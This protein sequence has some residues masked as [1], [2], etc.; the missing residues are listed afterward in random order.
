MQA[1]TPPSTH[2]RNASLPS[3]SIVNPSEKASG[4]VLK[5]SLASDAIGRIGAALKNFF[6]NFKLRYK[7]T[8]LYN[9]ESGRPLRKK[10][11]DRL[12]RA[13]EGVLNANSADAAQQI[14]LDAVTIGKLLQRIAMYK[15]TDYLHSLTLDTLAYRDK[16]YEW[17]RQDYRNLTSV[18]GHPL[19]PQ[20]QARYQVCEDTAAQ[21]IQ[22]IDSDI[23]NGIKET[24][25]DGIQDCKSKAQVSQDLFDKFG[26][27]NRSWKRIADT[28]TVNISNLASILEEVHTAGAGEKVYFQ[29]H[30][31]AGCCKKCEQANGKIA[32]WSA[33]PLAS[34]EIEDPF[35]SVAIW[36]SK[37][38][39]S[40]RG[41]L[42]PGAL[43]PHCRGF[44]V[45]WGAAE[46][47]AQAAEVN[48]KKKEWNEAV[49]NV[50]A[51]YKAQGIENPDDSTK[52]YTKRINEV[53]RGA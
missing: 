26:E 8:V 21:L 36:D 34:D 41:T 43:H 14:T 32:L 52:G 3:S 48:G 44:W 53:Y 27:V 20:E 24:L 47:N 30:E 42:A 10:D 22:K 6:G 17:I 7:G 51:E 33:T 19:S 49:R 37:Q 29:R 39:D 16:S 45:R 2:V 35:A 50:Q 25:L 40:K 5:K 1:V 46:F 23:R 11:F 15:S 12:L 9:P 4:N 18:L 31:M 38:P 28:E 13:I